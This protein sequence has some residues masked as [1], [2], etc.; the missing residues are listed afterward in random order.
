MKGAICLGVAV[1]VLYAAALAAAIGPIAVASHEIA[2]SAR[3]LPVYSAIHG[4]GASTLQSRL[5]LP[6]KLHFRRRSALSFEPVLMAA[7]R[8]GARV[9]VSD[10]F[11]NAVKVFS[12]RG[13]PLG[14]ITAGIDGPVGTTVDRNG[15]LYVANFTNSTVTEYAAG[16]TTPSMTVSVGIDQ[17]ISVAVGLDGTLYVGEFAN[18]LVLEF[19]PG[20]WASGPTAIITSLTYPEG[21]TLDADNNLYAAWNDQNYGG[22]VDTFAPGSTIG[23]NIG[24]A[25]GLTGDVKI[26]TAGNLV[27]ADQANQAIDIF[28]PGSTTPSRV[29]HTIGSDPYKVAFDKSERTLYVADP[30]TNTVLVFDYAT[31]IQ[32]RTIYSG[33]TS[34]LGVSVSPSAPF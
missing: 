5:G 16:Q 32:V 23:T 3:L 6:A 7:G 8:K 28:S 33:L 21:L 27:L 18:D 14:T 10:F 26:D 17:P 25:T 1:P 2:G 4:R 12:E 20:H 11:V 29:L 34:A 24:I 9:Y 22:Q 30:D 19:G 31:G 13:V 15:T